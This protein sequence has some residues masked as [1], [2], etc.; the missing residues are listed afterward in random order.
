[1]L[2]ILDVLVEILLEVKLFSGYFGEIEEWFFG[3]VILIV[4]IVGD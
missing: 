4:G 3:I 1:M 2:E